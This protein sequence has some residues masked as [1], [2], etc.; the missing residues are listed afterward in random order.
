MSRHMWHFFA[1]AAGTPH[2]EE[3]DTRGILDELPRAN[4]S[5]ML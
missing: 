5:F 1:D 4:S 3:R 2:M